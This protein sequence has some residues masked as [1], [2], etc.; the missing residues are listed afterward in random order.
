MGFYFERERERACACEEGRGR[1][2]ERETQNPKQA[3]SFELSAQSPTRGS[4][5]QTRDLRRNQESDR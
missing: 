4:I 3:P 5:S 1:A 2:R